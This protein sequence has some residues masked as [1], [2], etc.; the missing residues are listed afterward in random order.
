[1][2]GIIIPG[3]L[4]FG[5][6]FVFTIMTIALSSRRFSLQPADASPFNLSQPAVS[7]SDT[8]D[9]CSALSQTPAPMSRQ[10]P[11]QVI[12]LNSLNDVEAFLDRLEAHGFAEREVRTL[13]NASFAVR[14]R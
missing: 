4:L 14:W 9:G 2:F 1:M 8:L 13:G 5:G 10:F 7:C 11:W 6:L 3:L 12:S